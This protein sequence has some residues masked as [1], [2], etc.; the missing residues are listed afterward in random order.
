MSVRISGEDQYRLEDSEC[1]RL[2]E[3][4]QAVIAAVETDQQGA[5][6]PTHADGRSQPGRRA[7]LRPDQM[8]R[9]ERGE[10]I[11]PEE[12]RDESLRRQFQ[13]FHCRTRLKP[14]K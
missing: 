11:G 12:K 2:N 10:P 13:S 1:D 14:K 6:A 3:L 4:E 5:V 7:V 8:Q 9:G